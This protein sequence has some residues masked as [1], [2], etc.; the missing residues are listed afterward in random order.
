[1]TTLH[2]TKLGVR[3]EIRKTAQDTAGDLFEFDVVGR[4]RGFLTQAHVHTAQTER[5]EVIEGTMRLVIEGREHVLRQGE[6]MTVPAGASHRQLAGPDHDGP[7]RVRVQLRPA[8]DT[9]AFMRRLVELDVNRWGF[10]RPLAAARLVRDFGA[11]GHAAH[12]PI[13]VQRAL[14]RAI[15]RHA[16]PE[17]VFVDEWDVAAPREAVFDAIADART[18]PEWW[19]PVYIEVDADGEPALGKESRQHFKGR[20]PYHLHTRSR[21]VALE[22]PHVVEGEVD[23]DLRGHGR[24]TLTDAPGGGT[25]VRFDWR[26]HADRA[27][28]R[29][30]TP[31]LR[32]AF[33]W[34]H[35]WAIARAVEG[36][37]PYA[38]ARA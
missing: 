15:L 37:E 27:L 6:A 1:M 18:Y 12:P 25:H 34:N 4:A 21:I 36:L 31:L 38:R 35:A 10:P 14:S 3:V 23:G 5:H 33:R 9:E 11:T 32:P 26:V 17:Y 20:L 28:L 24:W 16:S 7:G 13:R 8:G 2:I 22:P 30:L 29:V 19:K